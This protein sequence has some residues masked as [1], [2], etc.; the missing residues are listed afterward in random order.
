MQEV[1]HDNKRALKHQLRA[2]ELAF[3]EQNGG[4]VATHAACWA[5]VRWEQRSGRVRCF[6]KSKTVMSLERCLR[7]FWEVLGGIWG[8]VLGL[9]H[10]QLTP[11]YLYYLQLH[12]QHYQLHSLRPKNENGSLHLLLFWDIQKIGLGCIVP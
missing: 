12:N 7:V 3:E 9:N 11:A 5:A 10:N 2:W 6:K 1:L 4:L 8:G